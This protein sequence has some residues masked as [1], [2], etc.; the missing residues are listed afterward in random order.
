MHVFFIR[1]TLPQKV[2]KYLAPI[3]IQIFYFAQKSKPWYRC[4]QRVE[5]EG[6]SLIKEIM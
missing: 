5:G 1:T 3:D 2:K 6:A 4:L